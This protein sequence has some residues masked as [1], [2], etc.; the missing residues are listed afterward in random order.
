MYIVYTI[1]LYYSCKIMLVNTN[2]I[3][4]PKH[5]L[6]FLIKNRRLIVVAAG[7][8]SIECIHFCFDYVC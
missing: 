7:E 6:S 3:Y 1:L 8:V 2:N 4:I 5:F